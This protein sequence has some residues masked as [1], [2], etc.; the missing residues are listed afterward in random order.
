VAGRDVV[1]TKK[2]W[3]RTQQLA[4]SKELQTYFKAIREIGWGTPFSP[5]VHAPLHLWWQVTQQDRE[6]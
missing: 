4:I 1:L 2:V 5:R 3:E 6:D